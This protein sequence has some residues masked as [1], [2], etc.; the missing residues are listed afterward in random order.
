VQHV[1]LPICDFLSNSAKG[2]FNIRTKTH[3]SLCSVQS[4]NLIFNDIL[5]D[6]TRHRWIGHESECT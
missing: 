3:S 4:V 1:L 6:D 5:A 2:T